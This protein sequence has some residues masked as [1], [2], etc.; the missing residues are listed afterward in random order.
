M[1]QIAEER[2]HSDVVKLL[3][4]LMHTSIDTEVDFIQ[5]DDVG[6][7]NLSLNDCM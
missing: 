4:E 6:I 5:K 3:T 2:Q 1:V 7:I